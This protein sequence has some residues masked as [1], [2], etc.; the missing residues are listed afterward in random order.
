[1]DTI[2]RLVGIGIALAIVI[3]V[4]RTMH[5]PMAVQ[6]S[7]AFVVVVLLLLVQPLR[8]IVSFFSEIG[9]RAGIDGLYL[10]VI[11]RAVGI[12]YIASLGAQIAKDAGEQGVAGMIELGGKILI[13]TVGLPVFS[14]ILFALLRLL[15]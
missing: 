6:I 14:G 2:I 15:P 13:L 11:L 9:R 3:G 12:A 4:V 10:D 8:E 5:P 7:L 1:M